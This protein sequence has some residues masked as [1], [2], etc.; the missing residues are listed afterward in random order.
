MRDLHEE[1]KDIPLFLLMDE[2]GP[3]K[4]LEDGTLSGGISEKRI[5][6][7]PLGKITT[8]Q[9]LPNNPRNSS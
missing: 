8:S 4:W 3:F 7:F 2:E 6:K 1:S 9:I 5:I